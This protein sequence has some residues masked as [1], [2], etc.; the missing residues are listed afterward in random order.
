[1]MKLLALFFRVVPH[2]HDDTVRANQFPDNTRFSP[3]VAM[4]PYGTNH[5]ARR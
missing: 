3:Y 5:D 4:L 1:M 2:P